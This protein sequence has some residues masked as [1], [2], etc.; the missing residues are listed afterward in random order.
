MAAS[1]EFLTK[2]LKEVNISN[3]CSFGDDLSHEKEFMDKAQKKIEQEI[4]DSEISYFLSKRSMSLCFENS[5]MNEKIA[6]DLL[7]KIDWLMD[8]Y[9]FQKNGLVCKIFT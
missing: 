2:K 8:E 7:Y 9:F 5:K 1:V 6:K 4:Q 3:D